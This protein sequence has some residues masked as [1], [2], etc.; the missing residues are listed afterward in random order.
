MAK[1]V[2]FIMSI[3]REELLYHLSNIVPQ[4]TRP[5]EPLWKETKFE[6]QVDL[7]NNNEEKAGEAFNTF[8][9][10]PKLPPGN[11]PQNTFMHEEKL[12]NQKNFV[13]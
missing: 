2:Q 4:T 7:N 1:V 8:T 13:S 6:N 10:F 5:I 3:Y 12:R 9:L 11:L